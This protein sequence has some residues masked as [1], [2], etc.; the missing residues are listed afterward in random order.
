M[1]NL[2]AIIVLLFVFGAAGYILWYMTQPSVS[3]N[4][5]NP[6]IK[7]QEINDWEGFK[8][9]L[10]PSLDNNYLETGIY[11]LTSKEDNNK[12]NRKIFSN[13][14]EAF[15]G[16]KVVGIRG[17]KRSYSS[18]GRVTA[19]TSF[20]GGNKIVE[21]A[22]IKLESNPSLSRIKLALVVDNV[23][24]HVFEALTKDSNG[25]EYFI[26][27]NIKEKGNV[28]KIIENQITKEVDHYQKQ[29]KSEILG[30]EIPQLDD[31]T[32]NKYILEE[33][34]MTQELIDIAIFRKD[35]PIPGRYMTDI[36]DLE[37][38]AAE[39]IID[40]ASQETQDAYFDFTKKLDVKRQSK[41]KELAQ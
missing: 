15:V 34:N 13:K 19:V 27:M 6:S 29:P 31:A 25:G 14:N 23:L 7:A 20:H 22:R 35:K 38:K 4:K 26:M 36:I 3:E 39:Y 17:L 30:I 40:H 5:E 2:S 8:K 16:Q 24:I 1:K 41:L 11:L 33:V 28:S 10:A 9:E 21:E 32:L 12:V 37:S 18:E